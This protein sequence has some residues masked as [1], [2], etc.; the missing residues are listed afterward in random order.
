MTEASALVED[1]VR[2]QNADGG[3]GYSG[4]GPLPAG[5]GFGPPSSTEPT[6]LAL[7]ALEAAGVCD[8]AHERGRQWLLSR[9]RADGGWAP[10]SPVDASTSVTSTALLALSSFANSDA[11]TRALRW[12]LSQV[13]PDLGPVQRLEFWMSSMPPNEST[14]GGSPWFPGTA[15]W[16]AP[17][18]MATLAFAQACSFPDGRRDPFVSGLQAQVQRATAYL[19]SRRCQDGG[20]NHGGT[21]FRSAAAFSYPEMTGMALLAVPQAVP[22]L[23]HTL[24][25]AGQMFRRPGS[26]EG[27]SWLRLALYKHGMAAEAE[28]PSPLQCRTPRDVF[29]RL[30]AVCASSPRNKLMTRIGGQAIL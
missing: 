2:R 10:C 19:L 14:M 18:V 29:L 7:L 23:S 22:N 5:L 17:T 12:L 24:S 27:E 4:T 28:L 11:Q 26:S 9:Q 25:L 30:L 3:W 6:A 21:Q 15:A 1:T 16:V 8:R 20:W 13:K